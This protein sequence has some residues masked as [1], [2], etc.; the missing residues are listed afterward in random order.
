MTNIKATHK[1]DDN[2]VPVRKSGTASL[3]D[4]ADDTRDLSKKDFK[5]LIRLVEIY[6]E[7]D[8]LGYRFEHLDDLIGRARTLTDKEWKRTIKLGKTLR[9]ADAELADAEKLENKMKGLR[10]EE[11]QMMA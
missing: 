5:A 10:F 11:A 1:A 4:L 2:S 8:R 3:T 9:K 7:A 6:R